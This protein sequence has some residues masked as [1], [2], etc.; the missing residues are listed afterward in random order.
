MAEITSCPECAKMLRVPDDLIGKKV[1]CPGCGLMFTASLDRD[2]EDEEEKPRR[3]PSRQIEEDDEP[4]TRKRPRSEGI[5]DRRASRRGDM[6]DDENDRP[7]RRRWE[8][9]GEDRPR[10]RRD[11]EDYEDYDRRPRRSRREYY[12]EDDDYPGGRRDRQAWRGV[13]T[14]IHL[15]IL[16]GWLSLALYGIAILGGG[17]LFALGAVTFA[18]MMGGGPGGAPPNPGGAVGIMGGVCILIAILGLMGLAQ[19][20]LQVTGYGICMQVPGRQSAARG[21]CIGA[22]TCMIVGLLISWG[23]GFLVGASGGPRSPLSG[24]GIGNIAGNIGNLVQFVAWTLWIFCLRS[25]CYDIRAKELANR[26]LTIYF[27]MVGFT[28]IAF[29]LLFGIGFAIGFSL[30]AGGGPA[31]GGPNPATTLSGGIIAVFV[32]AVFLFLG[33]IGIYV[34]YLL[35]LQEIRQSLDRFISRM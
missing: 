23:G 34:W 8:D 10:R 24:L 20:I 28:F 3:R 2:D 12:D 18:N 5:S 29:L 7:S 27:S 35:T 1:R 32:L 17:L 33:W 31:A 30:A 13:R 15:V 26:I 11:D 25:I 14:G 9:E 4:P 6:D 22:F 19:V 21:L 16:S